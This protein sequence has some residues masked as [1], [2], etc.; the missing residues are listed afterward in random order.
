MLS[1]FYVEP[2]SEIFKKTTKK[3][4]STI[5]YSSTTFIYITTS[6]IYIFFTICKLVSYLCYLLLF[7]RI[8]FDA[9]QEVL[10]GGAPMSPSITR[11]LLY[12]FR[13]GKSSKI[14]LSAREIG[15]LHL[16]IKGYSAKMIGGKLNIS[17]D[18]TRFCL[19]NIYAKLPV[20][21]GKEAIVKA[22]SEH[23]I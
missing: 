23:I 11:K 18:T 16:L 22:L 20:N 4:G 10:E 1:G 12:S 17:F 8:G 13:H 3:R 7:P 21:C 2:V 9:I 6:F 19:R 15:V 14:A 5:L